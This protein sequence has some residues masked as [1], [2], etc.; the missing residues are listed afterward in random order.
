MKLYLMQH[1]DAYSAEEDPERALSPIGVEQAKQAGQACKKLALQFD[2]LIS[3]P[4]RRARQTAALIAEAIRYPYSDIL[5][6]NAVL[7]DRP[8]EEFLDVLGKEPSDSHIL[9][10]SHLPFLDNLARHLMQGGELIFENAGLTGLEMSG[11]ATAR[12][13]CH[14]QRRHLVG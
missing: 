11:P 5:T 13:E 3:S 10:V 1:A 2:L 12:L 14:L 7:P 6:T 4:K 8:A 9:V